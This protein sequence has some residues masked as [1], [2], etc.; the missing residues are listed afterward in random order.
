MLEVTLS[1]VL[2]VP[3]EHVKQHFPRLTTH[4]AA[5][6]STNSLDSQGFTN[7]AP[8]LPLLLSDLA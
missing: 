5:A 4:Q 1:C 8:K 6:A 7:R 2:D 3:L